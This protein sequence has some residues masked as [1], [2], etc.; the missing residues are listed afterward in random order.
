MSEENGSQERP[1]NETSHESPSET[2]W[3]A[4]RKTWSTPQEVLQVAAENLL[5]TTRDLM[6]QGN[7]RRII[8]RTD[9]GRTLLDIP[10]NVGLVGAVLMPAWVAVGA[11]AAIATGFTIVVERAGGGGDKAPAPHDSAGHDVVVGR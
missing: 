4:P 10:L 2:R 5:K 6:H 3:S 9:R 1:A 8:V 11:M 7:V